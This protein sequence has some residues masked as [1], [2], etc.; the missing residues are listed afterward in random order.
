MEPILQSAAA[1]RLQPVPGLQADVRAALKEGNVLTGEVLLVLGDGTLVVGVGRHRVPTQTQADMSVGQRFQFEVEGSGDE[2]RL[3]VLPQV[4]GAEGDLIHALREHLGDDQPSECLLHD[5]MGRLRASLTGGSSDATVLRLLNQLGEHTFRPGTNGYVLRDLVVRSGLGFEAALS[6]ASDHMLG[7]DVQPPTARALAAAWVRA[8]M[9]ESVIRPEIARKLEE[10]LVREL[11][12]IREAGEGDLGAVMQRLGKI[13]VQ[14]LLARSST[15]MRDSLLARA[16]AL[17]NGGE[18]PEREIALLRVWLG[19]PSGVPERAITLWLAQ[20]VLMPW[21]RD[22]K[23]R[24]LRAEGQLEPGKAC[25]AVERALAGLETEQ[26]F[27]LARG[28]CDEG[29]LVS[30]PISDGDVRGTWTTAHLLHRSESDG[31]EEGSKDGYAHRERFVLGVEFSKLGPVRAEFLMTGQEVKLRLVA[32]R[33]KTA[34]VM[35]RRLVELHSLF[36]GVEAQ[37]QLSF[38][39]GSPGDASVEALLRDVEYL[40]GHQLLGNGVTDNDKQHAGNA[41]PADAV[42]RP[43]RDEQAPAEQSVT[44]RGNV[45]TN[46]APNVT[47]RGSGTAADRMIALA[48]K[49]GIPVREASGLLGLLATSEIGEE[50]PVELYDVVARLLTYLY[51]INDEPSSGSR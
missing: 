13:M 1:I 15:T 28:R 41:R 7:G 34:S 14:V 39:Q 18:F 29:W 36:E 2:L 45:D 19:Q 16:D 20:A 12:A 46:A 17:V 24:L 25:S 48:R 22:L 32:D 21:H 51:Q 3:C 47:A 38:V 9:G 43:A 27:N 26:L 40:R 4:G 8:L 5:L 35:R 49:E 31:V 23:A 44:L 10:L 42:A 30:F 11:K 50:I 6:R 37:V 33:S